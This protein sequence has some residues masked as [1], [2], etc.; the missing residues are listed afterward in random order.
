M[1]LKILIALGF[2]FLSKAREIRL[3]EESVNSAEAQS[4]VEKTE[5]E[6]AVIKINTGA[7]SEQAKDLPVKEIFAPAAEKEAL[8]SE[9]EAISDNNTEKK[10]KLISGR[11][12]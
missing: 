12:A 6:A 3:A 1:I 9:N 8:A 4:E 10:S 2:I 11:S 7:D 5:S